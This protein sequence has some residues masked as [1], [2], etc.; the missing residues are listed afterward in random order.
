M[1]DEIT[2]EELQR[3][4]EELQELASKL[5]PDMDAEERD[6]LVAKIQKKA[7]K[8]QSMA[9]AFEAQENAKYEQQRKELGVPPRTPYT[10]V[11]LTEEQRARIEERTGV[12][13]EAVKI[14]DPSADMTQAMPNM[15][16]EFIEA[17]ANR[18]ARAVRDLKDHFAKME[19]D[20]GP[21][22]MEVIR[23]IKKDPSLTEEIREHIIL[24]PGELDL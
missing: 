20:A 15:P 6:R 9:A 24:A 18:Y 22:A 1:P 7:K 2:M 12:K 8:L 10:V 11:E 3:A 5:D 17:I 21:E 19:A 14:D 4:Q 16:P 23:L 13:V